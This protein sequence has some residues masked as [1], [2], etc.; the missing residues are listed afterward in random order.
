MMGEKIQTLRKGAG[1]TQDQLAQRVGVSRQAVS[2]WELGEAAPE[3]E[4]LLPL[5]RAL[6]VTVDELLEQPAAEAE[7]EAERR[8]GW[9]ALHWHWI[10]A[11]PAA[12]G[13]WHLAS[14]T[15]EALRLLHSLR[16]A[17]SMLSLQLPGMD[18]LW[19]IYGQYLS[20]DGEVLYSQVMW[21]MSRTWIT[22][23]A[24]V[25][26]GAA[27]FLWGRSRTRQKQKT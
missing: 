17:E 14:G 5:A 19:D 6:G 16:V 11:L 4:K 23:L 27:L 2:R 22:A 3:T 15:A 13:L 25:A 21:M 20:P 24:A 7:R 26:A 1:L 8:P 18:Y 10:G 9:L 12:W